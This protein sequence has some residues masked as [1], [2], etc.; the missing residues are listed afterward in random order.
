[1]QTLGVLCNI[2]PLVRLRHIAMKLDELG[3]EIKVISV[4]C[5]L[6]LYISSVIQESNL[7]NHASN[8]AMY[9][10]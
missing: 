10:P 8:A 2:I 9:A 3:S 5:S 4:L 6:Q 1:M 7:K